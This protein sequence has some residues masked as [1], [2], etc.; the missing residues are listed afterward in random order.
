[1]HDNGYEI[2]REL[3]MPVSA[4]FNHSAITISEQNKSFLEDMRKEMKNAIKAEAELL[5]MEED[6]KMATLFHSIRLHPDSAK[7]LNVEQ[8]IVLLET[9]EK[10]FNVKKVHTLPQ[11]PAALARQHPGLKAIEAVPV[12]VLLEIAVQSLR[13]LSA[14]GKLE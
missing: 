2:M 11:I 13:M 8:G 12:T 4:I 1:V 6:V 14:G 5:T 3:T 9:A 10:F 7:D